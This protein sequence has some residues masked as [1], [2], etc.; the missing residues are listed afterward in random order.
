MPLTGACT[1][2]L[3]VVSITETGVRRPDSLQNYGLNKIKSRSGECD[4]GF[5]SKIYF[6]VHQ[7]SNDFFLNHMTF[8]RKQVHPPPA[9]RNNAE[10]TNHQETLAVQGL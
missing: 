6:G 9:N 4:I 3:S 7:F 8:E 10:I 1:S 2:S 5:S